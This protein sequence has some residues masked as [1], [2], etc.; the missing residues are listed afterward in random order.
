MP[1]YV[2]ENKFV[3]SMMEK[4]YLEKKDK[5]A[6]F[7]G[8]NF[9]QMKITAKNSVSDEKIL[10]LKDSYANSLIP[11]L[12]DRFAEVYVIDLRY[13]H[14]EKVSDIIAENEIDRVLMVYNV[15]FL[16]EDRNF[17]WLE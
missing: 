16:N 6:S 15:D 1:K 13:F 4:S 9:A 11:F 10:V 5:Y 8:G 7:F 14:F 2:S 3:Y 12:A 17:I